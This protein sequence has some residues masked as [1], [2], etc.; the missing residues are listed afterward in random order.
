MTIWVLKPNFKPTARKVSPTAAVSTGPKPG[1]TKNGAA[2][3]GVPSCWIRW[4]TMPVLLFH[5][6]R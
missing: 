6:T 2:S 3:T 5:T 4:E 1:M